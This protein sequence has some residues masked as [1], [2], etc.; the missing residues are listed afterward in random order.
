MFE[1]ISKPRCKVGT[2]RRGASEAVGGRTLKKCGAFT[3]VELIVVVSIIALLISILLPALSKANKLA[4]CS[5]TRARL[6]ELAAGCIVYH[7]D[8]GYYPGQQYHS[9]LI[10]DG[11]NFTG[12]QWL[13]KALFTDPST[14]PSFPRAKYAP[15]HVEDDLFEYQNG[16]GN[17]YPDTISDRDD[18]AG[19]PMPVL[20]YPARLGVS[21]LGQYKEAD[22]SPYTQGVAWQYPSDDTTGGQTP[23]EKYI[24]DRRFDGNNSTTPYRPQEFLMIA[25]GMDRKYGTKDDIKYGW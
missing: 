3:L 13:A 7:D 8:N 18:T 11:G 16:S 9:E 25:A 24:K 20:Y 10:G 12:S 17:T 1:T 19:T 21:G 4:A 2:R 15:L 6:A 5:R 22:N 23:F 14:S